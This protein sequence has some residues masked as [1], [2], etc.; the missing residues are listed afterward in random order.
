MVAWGRVVSVGRVVSWVAV[1]V[2]MMEGRV[3]SSVIMPPGWVLT[4]AEQPQPVNRAAISA[5]ARAKLMIC[6]I[7]IPPV[8]IL[9]MLVCRGAVGINKEI[10]EPWKF[11]EFIDR[12]IS[13][14]GV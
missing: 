9:T 14:Y 8:R 13:N 11:F 7:S 1:G 2:G 12:L 10:L 4:L 6:F 3:V 5:S